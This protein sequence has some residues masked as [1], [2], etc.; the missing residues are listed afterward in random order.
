MRSRESLGSETVLQ[1]SR[2]TRRAAFQ[3]D[4]R[5]PRDALLRRLRDAGISIRQAERIT[6][7]GRKTIS[8]AYRK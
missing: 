4:D 2:Q 6:G 3:V 1:S 7:I 8:T 5:G